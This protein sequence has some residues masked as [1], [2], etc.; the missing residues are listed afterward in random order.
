MPTH[1]QR[2]KKVNMQNPHSA[3]IDFI[4]KHTSSNASI[5][6]AKAILSLYNPI[7]AFS[8]A[9]I[10]GPLD[11]NNSSLVVQ[12][13]SIYAVKGETTELKEAGKWICE[14]GTFERLFDLSKS[15]ADAREKLRRQW[16]YEREQAVRREEEHER[17]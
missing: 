1:D 9:E 5:G 7:H 6:L 15:M 16:E 13:V 3:A 10:L 14:S 12:M 17:L 4:K 8:I 11:Q 2:K